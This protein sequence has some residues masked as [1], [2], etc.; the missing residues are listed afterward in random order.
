MLLEKKNNQLRGLR[1]NLHICQSISPSVENKMGEMTCNS[2]KQ[3]KTL[4][5]RLA[6]GLL[7]NDLVM[8]ISFC[9]RVFNP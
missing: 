8:H 2:L 4:E 9:I 5:T 3:V 1:N 7:S 6:S